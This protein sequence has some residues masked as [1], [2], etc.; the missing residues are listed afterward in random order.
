MKNKFVKIISV[1]CALTMLI[2]CVSITGV[3]AADGE[4]SIITAQYLAYNQEIRVLA[5]VPDGYD[6]KVYV[7][8]AELS[9]AKSTSGNHTLFVSESFVPGFYGIQ[10]V[11]LEAINGDT[12]LTDTENINVF[13]VFKKAESTSMDFNSL[14]PMSMKDEADSS[15]VD[16]VKTDE[17]EVNNMPSTSYTGRFVDITN[18]YTEDNSS[19]MTFRFNEWA[20][21]SLPSI[22]CDPTTDGTEGIIEMSYDFM[23]TNKYI[24]QTIYPVCRAYSSQY[25]FITNDGVTYTS[26]FPVANYDTFCFGSTNKKLVENHWYNVRFIMNLNSFKFELYIDNELI[27][28]GD[29]TY[30]HTDLSGTPEYIY[31][32][33]RFDLAAGV[34][35]IALASEENPV[36]ISFDNIKIN[37]ISTGAMVDSVAYSVS[38]VMEYTSEKNAEIPFLADSVK[39]DM[40]NTLTC[41]AD[42]VVLQKADGTSVDADISFESGTAISAKAARSSIIV[43]PKQN[44]VAGENYKIVIGSGA[45]YGSV[46]YGLSTEIPFR[47]VSALGILYPAN[48][49]SYQQGDIV[50]LNACTPDAETVDLYIDDIRI[51]SLLP[52]ADDF[53][54]YDYNTS[55]AALGDHVLKLVLIKE[56]GTIEES[57]VRVTINNTSEIDVTSLDDFSTLSGTTE[58]VTTVS[59]MGAIDGVTMQS[60]TTINVVKETIKGAT[61]T[62]EGLSIYYKPTSSFTGTTKALFLQDTFDNTYSGRLVLEHDLYINDTAGTLNYAFTGSDSDGVAQNF[63]PLGDT[64]LFSGGKIGTH[65]VS[66]GGDWHKIKIVID[67]IQRTTAVYVDGNIVT[68]SDNLLDANKKEVDNCKQIRITYSSA[69]KPAAGAETFALAVDNWRVYKEY[70]LPTIN[71]VTVYDSADTSYNVESGD[72]ISADTKKFAVD[73]DNIGYVDTES[74]IENSVLTADGE[75]VTILNTAIADSVLTFETDSIDVNSNLKFTVGSDTILCDGVTKLGSNLEF[76]LYVANYDGIYEARNLSVDESAV[77]ADYSVGS[78]SGN[79]EFILIEA[80]YNGNSLVSLNVKPINTNGIFNASLALPISGADLFKAFIWD[81]SSIVAPVSASDVELVISSD[82]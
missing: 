34:Q 67:F 21:R 20:D 56:D 4:L 44:L 70:P 41:T 12:I 26:S 1:L 13:K 55:A 35:G 42:D 53:V 66:Y 38:D 37:H 43:T 9:V 3:F 74:L 47:A 82:K 52:D 75:A 51:T 19:A 78:V 71:S 50:R 29:F 46:E 23:T 11:K 45:K 81:G 48:G 22:T 39:V 72:I 5:D 36:N 69:T 6:A 63:Y 49:A 40:G 62:E 32:I 30:V 8:G 17:F 77:R 28:H 2:S 76:N 7:G 31:G 33:N 80:S 24:R 64:T 60:K 73:L 65:S 27:N 16:A 10:T 59:S 25:R 68:T 57:K 58:Y 15:V 18:T 79:S 61:R 14:E 54:T